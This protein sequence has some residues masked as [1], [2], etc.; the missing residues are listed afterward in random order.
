MLAFISETWLDSESG[1]F[2]R[3]LKK[4][5]FQITHAFRENKS[6]GGTAI[7]H[8]ES[9][10]GKKWKASCS[11]FQSFEYSGVFFAN[12]LVCCIYRKQ[13]ISID[14]FC[15]EFDRFLLGI[16]SFKVVIGGDFNVWIDED[17]DLEKEKLLN[18]MH[19]HG[20]FNRVFEPTHI[21][22]HTLDQLY[23]NPY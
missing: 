10:A 11:Q 7:I 14:T 22:G 16:G 19:N 1:V 13:E 20:F 4:L 5:S 2:S 18:L 6:G 23:V 15:E 17:F 21:G 3:R 12:I 8:H 9:L